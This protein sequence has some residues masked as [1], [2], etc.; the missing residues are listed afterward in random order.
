ML[1]CTFNRQNVRTQKTSFLRNDSIRL[2]EILI[3]CVP[4][5]VRHVR[6]VSLGSVGLVSGQTLMKVDRGNDY[7]NLYFCTWKIF[8]RGDITKLSSCWIVVLLGMR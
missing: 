7:F 8:Y 3:A 5:I 4:H 1:D 2:R 6:L